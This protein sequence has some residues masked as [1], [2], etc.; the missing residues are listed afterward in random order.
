MSFVSELAG[1]KC[2]VVGAGVTGRAVEKAL[3]K[4]GAIPI[5]FDEKVKPGSD[6]INQIPDLIDMAVISPGWRMDHPVINKLR[7]KKIFIIGEVDFAWQVKQVLAPKQVWVG[8]TGTNGKTTT[9]QMVESIFESAKINGAVCGNVGR[10]VIEAVVHDQPYDY[11]AL[12]LSSFQIQWSDLPKYESVALLNIAEDH[13]D[14]HGSFDSYAAAKLKLLEQ[15]KKL[16]VNKSDKELSKRVSR[17]SITWFSLGTP[18]PGELGVVENLLVDRAFSPSETEAG[19]IAE[20]I[21]ISPTVPHN[22]LNA[23]AAAAL[24]LSIG[25]NYF[26]VKAGLK[27]FVTDHH[28]MELVLSKN[29]ISWVDDSKATNPH[30]ATASL[31]SY[32]NIIWIAG[33]LAKGASMDELVLNTAD[34]IKS[35]ILIGQDR[36]MIAQAVLKH[37]PKTQIFRIDLKSDG[38]QLMLDVVKQAVEIAKAGDTVLLAPDCASMDQ[39][40]S[41]AG[42]GQAFANAVR[43]VVQ[44]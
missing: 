19:E 3:K 8:L 42:R 37:S 28:R 1:K 26:A 16:I 30:A 33:G 20:L 31:H 5:L 15:G 34:R 24:S 41:Y 4:F 9:I 22:V 2:L 6:V 32:F 11:L 27:S 21:D 43:A 17:D 29:E 13:I 10:T 25:I 18:L 39:F 7:Q 38:N 12:E 14:W 35:V 44:A 36:E 40:E 23:L